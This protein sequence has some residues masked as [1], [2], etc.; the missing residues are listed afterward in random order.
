KPEQQS[1][2]E[3]ARALKASRSAI[4]GA[5]Q[6][7]E[8]RRVVKRTRV[9]GDRNDLICFDISGFENRGFDATAYLRMAALFH[10]GLA[11]VEGASAE[12]QSQLQE[13]TRFAEFLAE[14]MPRLQK[15][16]RETR[17]SKRE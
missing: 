4:V 7:L 15:D 9:A 10:E 11:F 1:V 13:L 14:R 17:D 8:S 12:R 3:L 2:N 5:V 6:L 16:W